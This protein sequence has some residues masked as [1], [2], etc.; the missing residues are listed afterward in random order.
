M[1]KEVKADDINRVAMRDYEEITTLDED[2]MFAIDLLEIPTNRIPY[3]QLSKV[4][5]DDVK[6]ANNYR[7]IKQSTD[8]TLKLQIF[9]I[10]SVLYAEKNITTELYDGLI[11]NINEQTQ[12]LIPNNWQ[13]YVNS[14]GDTVK[15]KLS[16][17]NTDPKPLYNG[18]AYDKY[19]ILGLDYNTLWNK[20]MDF[21]YNAELDCWLVYKYPESYTMVYGINPY[22]KQ[23]GIYE[24]PIT[25]SQ[26]LESPAFTVMIYVLGGEETA[27]LPNHKSVAICGVG[28]ETPL[29]TTS[30][31]HIQSA[32]GVISLDNSEMLAGNLFLYLL[33]KNSNTQSSGYY[34]TFLDG[35][36]YR[37]EGQ[38]SVTNIKLTHNPVITK[39][40]TINTMISTDNSKFFSRRYGMYF[41]YVT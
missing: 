19:G 37:Y 17:N 32:G 39:S 13:N 20:R 9:N 22:D 23:S 28:N 15:C 12:S 24:A 4:I 26:I 34:K 36:D 35:F 38:I 30:Q 10:S 1:M 33:S 3:Q 40:S 7:L 25:G 18:T 11:L 6:D 27:Q 41:G 2:H 16:F 31:G 8:S 21:K 29:N 14:I 5:I